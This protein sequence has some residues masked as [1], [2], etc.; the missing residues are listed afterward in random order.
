MPEI[1]YTATG[2]LVVSSV[3]RR[4]AA[5][6]AALLEGQIEARTHETL[7]RSALSVLRDYRQSTTKE[8]NLRKIRD[9]YEGIKG[10]SADAG[11]KARA[12]KAGRAAITDE[13]DDG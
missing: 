7:M 5:L 11:A 12:A 13:E 2:E 8:A 9:V 1:E 4:L 6:D 3:Q 10:L